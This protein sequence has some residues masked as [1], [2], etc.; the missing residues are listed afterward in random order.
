MSDK[1]RRRKIRC[2]SSLVANT[3][4]VAGCVE[5]PYHGWQFN[6][7]GECTDVPQME[8]GGDSSRRKGLG[9]ETLQTHITGDLLWAF[10]GSEVTGEM[11][12]SSVLP[13]VH[14]P[15]LSRSDDTKYFVRE[16]PVRAC[17]ECII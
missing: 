2:A 4:V 17:N 13:E 11:F 10:F 6:T 8:G 1:Q 15:V 16:L 5:C 9:V 3:T 7:D 14:Y 12:D